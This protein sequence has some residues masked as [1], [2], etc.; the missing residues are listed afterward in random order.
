MR[1]LLFPIGLLVFVLLTMQRWGI[2]YPSV[3]SLGLTPVVLLFTQLESQDVLKA[4]LVEYWVAGFVWLATGIFLTRRFVG[5]FLSRKRRWRES[6]SSARPRGLLAPRINASYTVLTLFVF[7][8]LTAPFL[9]PFSPTSQ[10]DLITTR[11]LKPLERGIVLSASVPLD[12]VEP[13][14]LTSSGMGRFLGR[15]NTKLLSRD[16]R[17]V[18]FGAQP[19]GVNEG[20]T[21]IFF[22]G[23]DNLGRD[24]LSRIVYG[25]RVSLGIGF[26][27]MC[28]S[29]VLGSIVGLIAGLLGGWVD[30]LLMRLT[31][32][33]LA[34]PSLFLIIALVA[35]L[36]NSIFL[37]VA[38][39]AMT[40]WMGVARLIRG[41]V[42]MLR[43][44]EFVLAAR[45]LGRS[46]VQIIRDHMLP[47]VL[48]TILLASVLQLGNVVLAEAALSF[49]GLGIQPPTPSLGNMIGESLAYASSAWWVGFFPGVVLS[50]LVVSANVVAENV[51][52]ASSLLP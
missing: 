35:F 47:N 5:L 45:L 37:L 50:A 25:T 44:R 7:V 11:F 40:G 10:G 23:T 22:L 51:Q 6:D 43:D 29:I 26:A 31:D 49:L 9:A 8:A 30:R 27:A 39:L 2:V 48:P 4:G 38:V 36:G 33:F 14:F 41:E 28:C 18:R 52:K 20:Q 1:R 13:S 12:Q 19:P 34:F 24:V 46:S 16:E 15:M 3:V 32:L 21:R 17:I 42:L